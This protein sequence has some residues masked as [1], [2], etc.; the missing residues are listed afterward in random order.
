MAYAY[1]QAFMDFTSRSSEYAARQLVPLLHEIGPV[2]S[3]LDV[4]CATGTWLRVWREL[5][6]EDICGVDGAY[7]PL[8]SLQIPL[9]RFRDTDLSLPFR[10][11]RKFDLVQSFEVGEH[12][13]SAASETFVATLVQ[14]STGMIAFSAAVPGQGGEYHVN[15]QPFEF[16]RDLFRAHGYYPFD[17]I[18]P[19]IQTD[20]RISYWY[21]Y[22][23]ILYIHEERIATLS[24][25]VRN[26]GIPQSIQIPDVSPPLF[27][28][29]KAAVK[30]L[31][32]GT[33]NN[34]AR[35]KAR[36]APG[37]KF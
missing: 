30:L 23:T 1:D 7:V 27:R 17:Y 36:V 37:G 22:N 14:H 9:D 4:G 25:R 28:L 24:E 8:S 16:W 3:V 29:R 26:S 18:R 15:E 20:R 12:I 2:S 31:P 34:L 19:K 5:G 6:I 32:Y 13:K 35:L 21:R 10:L 11:D 33:Q